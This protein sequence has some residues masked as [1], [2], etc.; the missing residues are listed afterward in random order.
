MNL[1]LL[2]VY[3]WIGDIVKILYATDHGTMLWAMAN[4][5][6]WNLKVLEAL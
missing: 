1:E 4:V 2:E 3:Y 5:K 6:P